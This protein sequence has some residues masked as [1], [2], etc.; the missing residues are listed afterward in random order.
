[1]EFSPALSVNSDMTDEQLDAYFATYVPLSNLPTPPPAKE[2]PSTPC[3][4]SPVTV[5]ASAAPELQG[6]SSFASPFWC[7]HVMFPCLDAVRILDIQ[8]LRGFISA[9]LHETAACDVIRCPTSCGVSTMIVS[10]ILSNTA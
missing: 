6:Q 8:G 7:V 5:R 3:S 9:P 4:T 2:Q 10:L 1:M